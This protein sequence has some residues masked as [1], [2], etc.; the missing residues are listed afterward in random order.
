MNKN[1][2][3]E[4]MSWEQFEKSCKLM[5]STIKNQITKVIPLKNVYGPPRGGL[6][7]AVCL[8]HLLD[9][10]LILDPKQISKNTLIVDD[11]ADTGVTLAELLNNYNIPLFTATLYYHQQSAVVPDLW[12]HEKKDKWIVFPWEMKQ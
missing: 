2:T 4:F 5:A 10:D 8:S 12:L 7:I 3:K 1:E 11:I 6:P 9:I